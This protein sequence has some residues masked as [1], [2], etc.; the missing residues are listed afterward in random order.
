MKSKKRKPMRQDKR[1][2]TPSRSDKRY[3]EK[4]D[5]DERKERVYQKNP[6]NDFSWYNANPLLTQAAAS[7]PYP[8]RPGMQIPLSTQDNMLAYDVPGVL[9]INWMPTIGQSSKATDPA[10]IAAKEI[11][12]TVRNAFSGSLDADGPDYIMYFMA[13]DSI[14]SYIG[15]MKRIFRI[16]VTY[17]PQNY[18]IPD[19]LLQA[20]GC[21]KDMISLLKQERMQLFQFINELVGMTRRF[22]CPAVFSVFNRHY[23]MNDN[24]YTDAPDAN[25]QLYVFYQS[26]Y[27]KFELQ[28][29]PDNVPAGG[30]TMVGQPFGATGE[31]AT[32]SSIYEFGR[33]LIDA[34]A[35]WEDSYTISGYLQ[36]AFEGTP[37]FTVDEVQLN[38]VFEPVYIP[39]V[40]A[41]IENA[42]VVGRLGV[43]AWGFNANTNY[44]SQDPKTNAVLCNPHV[45]VS[46]DTTMV[47]ALNPIITIRSP[48]PT[49]IDT[50]EATRLTAYLDAKGNV[51][52][53]TEIPW[54]FRIF[55]TRSQSQQ[56]GQW[57]MSSVYVF[58]QT[59]FGAWANMAA[60]YS[61]L[62]QF[63]WHPIME[64]VYATG[65]A[66]NTLSVWGDFHNITVISPD[67]LKELNK[68]C[69]YSE[70]G[71]FTMR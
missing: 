13:L 23:W 71:S 11:Y 60:P 33:S 43:D 26:H 54:G 62:S 35:G 7:V 58:N 27:Y 53:G 32:M 69:L 68:V 37:T 55:T 31:D 30:L 15:A 59:T 57:D 12:A 1:S 61:L 21:S 18:A 17:T 45:T 16:L 70:F 67:Q 48:N 51:L 49:V 5:W 9:R 39:E 22:R 52:C 64:V 42:H 66:N 20:L 63:D 65:G 24:V 44:V 41:Q 28:N 47:S 29:T 25:S 19:V 38:E 40:L 14:F 46:A 6:F 56:D 10:S 2:S 8:Y 4:E 3:L 36:R 50:V 34:L